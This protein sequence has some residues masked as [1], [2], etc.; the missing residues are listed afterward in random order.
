MIHLTQKNYW[1][2]LKEDIFVNRQLVFFVIL[3][4]ALCFGFAITNYSIG[5]DDVAREYYLY[6][7]KIGNMIQQG[8]LLHV[9]FNLLTNTVDFIPYFNDFV[10]AVLYALSAL[11][12]CALF[13]FIT[14][15]K[16]STPALI[17]FACIYL[18]SSI[19]AEK[20]IYNLDVVVTILSYC[21]SA[22]ALMYAYCFVKEKK[23]SLLCKAVPVLMVAIASY[24]TFMFLYFCGVFA[25]FILEIVV[26]KEH[27]TF[28]SILQ[29]GIR[30]AVILFLAIGIYYGLVAVLQW[31]YPSEI[32]YI[33]YN[34]WK[35]SGLGFFGT[36]LLMTKRIYEHFAYSCSVGYIPIIVFTVMT[37]A[38]LSLF[39]FLSW[40]HR[41]PWLLLCFA[42]LWIGNFPIHYVGGAFMARAGQTFCF[43]TSFVALI[44]VGTV[45]PHKSL[46][47]VVLAAV[48]LLVFVQ[49]ADMNRWFYNDHVRYKKEAFIIDTLANKVAS[50]MDASKPLIFTNAPITGYLN[51][52]LY[53]GG[54]VNGNSMIY[55]IGY[56]FGEKTQPFISEVFRMHGYDFIVSPTAEQYDAAVVEAEA[57]PVW[58][59]EGCIQEFEDFI[60]VNFG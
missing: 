34:V 5:V 1:K 19:L 38:G 8:R 32:E 40:K 42:A 30:Y 36:F 6:S 9:G 23:L 55:W 46:R 18:S 51:T 16:F 15:R 56:A 52:D 21:C 2:L 10:G 25:V 17:S 31:I 47:N 14:D 24:E 29:E 39:V 53:P 26:N 27:K 37:F 54:H 20:F 28:I 3:T 4:T 45:E 57:M 60:V 44:L 43:F 59:A 50:Q 7:N 13:Q 49:S 35:E 41:N 58:P 11:L 12:Y 33:R 22:I 48:V